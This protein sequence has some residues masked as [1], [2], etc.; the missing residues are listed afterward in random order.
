M[1]P[2]TKKTKVVNA[3]SG[4]N[5]DGPAS[6]WGPIEVRIVPT[7]TYDGGTP[8]SPNPSEEGTDEEAVEPQD[9]KRK[10]PF[11]YYSNE[12]NRLSYL[13]HR[14]NDHQDGE[15]DEHQPPIIRKTMLSF[16]VHPD[17][18]LEDMFFNGAA[19]VRQEE[20]N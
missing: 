6:F 9:A 12:A 3:T 19:V 7:K 5:D 4:D 20:A 14:R 1:E 17:L 18:M 8:R 13:L 10:D 15:P 11:L 2:A 16:E